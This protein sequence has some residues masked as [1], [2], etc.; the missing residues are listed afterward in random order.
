MGSYTPRTVFL[1]T[2]VT[3]LVFLYLHSL[4]PGEEKSLIRLVMWER[5]WKPNEL[6][7]L[8]SWDLSAENSLSANPPG[9]ALWGRGGS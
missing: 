2:R 7:L 9:Q 5:G 6:A 4:H 8:S 1:V 3:P